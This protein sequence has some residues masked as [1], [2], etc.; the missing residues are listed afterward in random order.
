MA[1]FKLGRIRFIWKGIWT[2]GTTYVKDDVVRVNGKVFIC[3]IGHTANAD[4]YVDSENIPTRWNQIADG[5]E[6]RGDWVTNEVY[7]KNDIVKYGG[8]IYICTVGHTSAATIT[9]GLENDLNL[10]DSTLSKWDQFA[11]S[12]DWKNDWS[13]ATR[14]K[15]NDIVKYG[16]NLYLCNLGHTSASTVAQGLEG[17]GRITPGVQEDIAKWD[18]YSEAFDWKTDWAVSTRY[19]INDVVK[20]GGTT[21][22]CNLGHTS[23]ATFILGLEADQSK[24]DYFNQGIEY[25]GDWDDFNVSY[26]INDVVK[27]GSGLWI[28]TAK[29][30]SSQTTTFEADEDAGRWDRFVEG[31]EFESS[32]NTLTIYQPGDVIT[33]GGF[34]YISKTNHSGIAP[35]TPTTGA[36]NWDLFTTGFKLQNDWNYSLDYKI[37][38]VVRLN[39]YTY[40]AI[41]DVPNIVTTATSSNVATKR[42]TVTDTTGFVVGMSVR[43]SGT[44]FGNLQNNVT[45]YVNSIPSLTEFTVR[46]TES[47]STPV[48][49]QSSSGSMTV[50]VTPQPPNASYWSRLNSG[51]R[52][53]GQWQ[54]DYDYVL[55][56]AVSYGP[57]TYI[58]INPHHS[59]GDDGSTLTVGSLVTRPDVD[60][61]GNYWNVLTV[62]SETNVL[63]TQGDIVYYGGAGPT[64]LPIGADGQVLV[65]NNAAAPQ[66]KYWGLIDQLY[67]V[68]INGTD[69]PAPT[70]G[71]TLD[72]PWNTIQY[73]CQ[74]IEK[75]ARNPNTAYA[76]EI[77]RQFI[78][79]E[80]VEWIDYQRTNNISPFVSGFTYDKT[81]CERDV[82][83]ILDALIKDVRQ[84][85][86][87]NTRRATLEYINNAPNVYLLG[88]QQETVAAL[89]YAINSLAIA[90]VLTN[91][92]PAANYQTLNGISVGNRILQITGLDAAEQD[93]LNQLA[94][95]KDIVFVNVLAGTTT[96]LPLEVLPQR[97]ILAKTGVYYETL[98]IVVPINTA[99]V[100]DELRSTNIRPAASQ[101][102]SGDVAKSLDALSRISAIISDIVQG[103]TVAKTTTGSNPNT[104]AQSQTKPF[105]TATQGTL[106]TGLITNAT[107]YINFYIN[108]IGSAP[109]MTGTNTPASAYDVYAAVRQLELNKDF[110]IAEVHAYIALTY[111]S[112]TYTLAA[113]AR[114]VSEYINAFKYD[115]IYTGNYAT[116]I[117]AQLYK[118]GVTGSIA[119]NMF[120][121]RNSTGL[122]NCTVQGLTGTLGAP[123]AYGTRRPTAGAYVSLDPGWGTGDTRAWITSRSC[124]VQNV[125][126]FGTACVGLMIDGNLHAGGNR[127]V[128]ANDFTQV[129]SDGIGVWCTNLARTELVS[130]FSYY[131]HIGYLAENGG[132]IRA[133]NG[134]S[135][136]GTFGTVSEGVDPTETPVTGTVNNRFEEAAVSKVITN[137]SAI[138]RLEF[139]NAGSDYTSGTF[140]F[141]GAG[142]N[143]EAVGNEV[144]DDAVFEVRLLDLDDSSG[145]FGGQDYVSVENVAQTGSSTAITLAATDA[146][147]S[148]AYVGMRIFLTGGTGQSQFGYINSY[149]SGTKVA[150]V[151]KESTGTAGWDHSVPG[152]TITAPDASTQYVIEPRLTFTA[153]AFTDT[154][155]NTLPVTV[156][157]N[158]VI[159]APTRSSHPATAATGGAGTLATFDVIRVGLV[160]TV[161]LNAGGSGYVVGNTLTIAGANVNGAT[162]TNNITITVTNV[163]S[164][165]GVIT[166]F[167]SSGYARGGNYI[168]VP[169]SGSSGM[170]SQDAVTW[171]S[172]TL[173]ATQAWSSAAFGTIGSTEYVVAL[174]S[175]GSTSAASS[176]N[177]G[178]TWALASLPQTGTYTAVAFGNNRFVGVRS[179]SATPVISTNGTT[180]ANGSNTLPTA[181]SWTSITYGSGKFVAVATGTNTA[182]YS[183]DGI[184]WVTATLPS[185]TTWSSVTYGNNRFVAVNSTGTAAAYSLNG[186]SWTAVSSPPG[187]NRVSYGQGVFLGTRI[188]S[189]GTS[190]WTSPDGIVW[191]TRTVTSGRYAKPALGNSNWTPRW[192]LI[193]NTTGTTGRYVVAGA[194]TQARCSVTDGKITEI[195]IVEPGSGYSS[196]PTMTVTDPNNTYEVPFTVRTGRGALA[197]PSFSNRGTLW[198]TA[199]ATITGNGYA[200]FFQPGSYV[201]VK[202][203]FSVPVLGSN[204]VFSGLPNNYYKLVTVTNLAGTGPY[205]ARLQISPPL[206]ISE[207]PAHNDSFESRI[208]YSQCRLTG[209]DFL[210]IGT[211]NFTNTN[212]P[213]L[214]LQNPVQASETV[215]GG[216]GRV[217]FT[218]TD[219]DGNFRVGDLFTI[220]QATGTASLNASAFNL[221][222]L[223]ELQL[224]SVELGTGGATITEFST[225]PFFTAD[226][227]SVIPTQR[228]IKAYIA[229]QIGSGSSTLNVNTLTAGSVFVSGSTITTTTGFKIT[230]NTKFEFTRGIDGYPVA[231]NLFLQG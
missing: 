114:D 37:G 120:F 6:W 215:E 193:S 79:R 155:T 195:R 132:K 38:D 95:L 202:D 14:Y 209:H 123:N 121:V 33:Y 50:T 163:T 220:E 207:A 208:R 59:E 180:W 62:G 94:D 171:T 146:N 221:A 200:D 39:G 100:G 176:T 179:D 70:W 230:V 85:G 97:T 225:D 30:T 93:A 78:Q 88:Q 11:E 51:I 154:V 69:S 124:Y 103:N 170:Y 43:F 73:A 122:R 99:V 203:L 71:I 53:F 87:A 68:D 82:G 24:W 47:G 165:A 126:T 45:Y 34:A 212:Y 158:E 1:E 67:Y 162:P 25:L 56:D 84:G 148:S 186:T 147:T 174:P 177:G 152:T 224:G 131:G 83:Y 98:P 16:G 211:G 192:A 116:I 190:I 151:Y 216:G 205:T 109:T 144:R 27:Y 26:K 142:I 128:V 194:T 44:L 4:F 157:I 106:L 191:T 65:V 36:V 145:Q 213:G 229:S 156:G 102:G 228:A 101:I 104:V 182:T 77:N 76:L 175:S 9:S 198:V 13:T 112:Y 12:F 15:E 57:N 86:N 115:L 66:W 108:A 150:Q 3:V 161:T 7:Y 222:G 32:W 5:S 28:C 119:E 55:G 172:S 42:I 164:P 196:A 96:N 41:V 173:P 125:T 72:K 140:T 10:G 90:A 18:V 46:V 178:Q 64:R 201:D 40:T 75:G 153:P 214:P 167:T 113:C 210:D 2:A 223:Q 218:S 226:S 127:S 22:V 135:S 61:S 160:Y 60:I 204:V 139:L 206:T 133:T 143:A 52:W 48:D 80:T 149:N 58:C 188:D 185:S 183:L 187:A 23:A 8:Q 136:Y 166:G 54:D 19:K 35:T 181:T 110:I 129:L 138:Q 20:F 159:Y 92:P 81:K 117:T 118:N 134:N 130:V 189:A 31:L 141:N 137:N 89:Q 107:A 169:I 21:Y 227:D 63:T 197:N 231:M 105:A 184:S 217:F 29:H 111:P 74:Q 49:V 168:A 91:T 199:T 17:L 219:Q